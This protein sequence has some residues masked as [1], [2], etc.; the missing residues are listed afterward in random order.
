MY[1]LGVDT[2]C[3]T[4]SVAIVDDKLNIIAEEKI[5]LSVKSGSRGLRQSEGY[6]QHVENLAKIFNEQSIKTNLKNVKCLASS[7]K[8]RNV[9]GSYMPVF[10]AGTNILKIL[11]SFSDENLINFSHQEGHIMAS[12]VMGKHNYKK[13]AIVV[14]MSGGTT[15]ILHKKFVDG[16]FKVDIVG[17]TLDI[18]VGQLIDRSGVLF[19]LAFPCGREMEEM[20]RAGGA[21]KFPVSTK[22]GYFNLSGME[23]YMA[24]Y[25]RKNKYKKEHVFYNLFVSIGKTVSQSVVHLMKDL[26]VSDVLL[27]GGAASNVIIK[28]EIEAEIKKHGGMVYY[29][30]PKHSTDNAVG[31]A[32]LC[33]INKG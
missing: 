11:S 22:G 31:I 12:S 7:D 21:V 14:Q 18:S 20:S 29:A 30:S 17:G 8:P 9:D 24:R 15:E 26:K 5:L 28:S 16:K 2:S 10:L 1:F 6:F 4:T 25:E 3:Y 27:T 33:A 23:S 19:G 32:M 13:E